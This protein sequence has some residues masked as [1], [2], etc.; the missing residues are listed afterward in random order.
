MIPIMDRLPSIIC[1]I[2]S[3]ATDGCSAAIFGVRVAA[4]DHDVDRETRGLKRCF[5]L[6]NMLGAVIGVMTAPSKHNMLVGIAAG[7]ENQNPA[8]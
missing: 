6:S 4:A 1:S 2:T 7:F 8:L 3:R 5:T